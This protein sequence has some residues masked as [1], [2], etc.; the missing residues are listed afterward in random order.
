MEHY[1]DFAADSGFPYMLI[2]AGC[3]PAGRY[4]ASGYDLLHTNRISICWR[5]SAMPSR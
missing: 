5:F 1:I 3:P 4:L 2:D